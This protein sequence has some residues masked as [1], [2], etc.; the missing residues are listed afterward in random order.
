MTILATAEGD[1]GEQENEL[2]V[3]LVELPEIEARNLRGD[4][5][6]YAELDNGTYGKVRVS[7]IAANYE[8]LW[9]VSFNYS[10][11]FGLRDDGE[12]NT[13]P[14]KILSTGNVYRIQRF[15]VALR[16]GESLYIKNI[17]I[18][19]TYGQYTTSPP[20][21]VTN[22]FVNSDIS[23]GFY[24]RG[25]LFSPPGTIYHKLIKNSVQNSTNYYSVSIDLTN[26]GKGPAFLYDA[27]LVAML[28]SRFDNS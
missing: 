15:S 2:P 1:A 20:A 3:S 24:S 16:P 18:R 25:N 28:V 12:P 5:W 22:I 8:R 17:A 26:E 7:S 13:Y 21:L 6:V 10:I 9:P 19:Y 14:L 27:S 11:S 4:E 23:G